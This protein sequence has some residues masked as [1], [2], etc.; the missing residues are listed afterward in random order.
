MQRLINFFTSNYKLN[1]ALGVSFFQPFILIIIWKFFT[2]FEKELRLTYKGQKFSFFVNNR[3]DL[4]VLSEIFV[5]KE[6]EF[7]Y[8]S[9]PNVILDLGANVGD[10]AIFYS[11]LFPEAKIFAVEPNP[12]VHDKLEKNTQQF[13]NIKICKCAVSDKTGKID[14]HFGDSHLGSSINYR[15]QNKNSV[16]VDVFS[17]EDFCKKEGIDKVDILKFDIEGAEEYLL[18]SDYLKTH[19]VELVGEMHDDLVSQP[20]QPMIDELN[21]KNISKKVLNKKRYIIHGT[22][23]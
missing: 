11:I 10:T 19:V 4:A 18:K 23:L 15:D 12:H 17:L 20:L 8:I 5:N 13:Q 21:L 9:K 22:N 6:Y 3:M 2:K 7:N 16:E 14:L 1:R